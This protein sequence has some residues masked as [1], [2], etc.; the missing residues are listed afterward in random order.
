MDLVDALTSTGGVHMPRRQSPRLSEA[1]QQYQTARSTRV[2][3]NTLINDQSVLRRFVEGLGDPYVHN[4]T[5]ERCEA[6]FVA[7]AVRQSAS[8]YNKVLTRVRGL[9]AF[10]HRRGWL[11]G[12]PLG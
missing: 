1:F 2:A 3:H 8:S 7:E 11:V 9:V 10:C 12:D 5:P 6:W 4:V